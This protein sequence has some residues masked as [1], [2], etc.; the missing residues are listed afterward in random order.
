MDRL[1]SRRS[2]LVNLADLEDKVVPE[3][4][5]DDT[6]LRMAETTL[7]SNSIEEDRNTDTNNIPRLISR[8]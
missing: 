4:G 3:G 6:N 7:D 5:E 8:T 1:G 2:Y